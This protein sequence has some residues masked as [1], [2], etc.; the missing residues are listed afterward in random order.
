MRQASNI[1]VIKVSKRFILQ[2]TT[3]HQIY[4]RKNTFHPWSKGHGKTWPPCCSY[5]SWPWSWWSRSTSCCW[6]SCNL[7]FQ[8]FNHIHFAWTHPQEITFCSF[9]KMFNFIH[10]WSQVRAFFFQKF[11][12]EL[13]VLLCV[14]SFCKTLNLGKWAPLHYGWKDGKLLSY[15]AEN[16]FWKSLFECHLNLVPMG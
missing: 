7:I 9:N 8:P 16:I 4:F 13:Q 2:K 1:I 3:F 14:D 6:W 15:H 5:Q 11:F 10:C 12:Q